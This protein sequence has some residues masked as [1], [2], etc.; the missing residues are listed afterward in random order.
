MQDPKEGKG[1]AAS[2]RLLTDTSGFDVDQ[3]SA[4]PT[5]RKVTF[6]PLDDD[7]ADDVKVYWKPILYIF[8]YIFILFGILSMH[9]NVL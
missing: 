2:S 1:R 3:G 8:S 5:P 6:S 9:G 4:P 7:E